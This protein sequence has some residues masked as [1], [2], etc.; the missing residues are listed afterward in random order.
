MFQYAVQML[1]IRTVKIV[2]EHTPLGGSNYSGSQDKYSQFVIGGTSTTSGTPVS[3]HPSRSEPSIMNR[4]FDG[5]NRRT[6]PMRE[7][8]R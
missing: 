5:L 8:Q 4:S 3:V 7:L 2:L 6:P 1:L